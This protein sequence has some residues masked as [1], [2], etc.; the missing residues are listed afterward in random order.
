MDQT[1]RRGTQLRDEA[2]CIRHHV[3]FF[4]ERPAEALSQS[5][6]GDDLHDSA[7]AHER[8]G[9]DDASA[10]LEAWREWRDNPAT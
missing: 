5:R 10:I 4:P 3:R 9:I 2:A 1:A 7:A 8:R 6:L